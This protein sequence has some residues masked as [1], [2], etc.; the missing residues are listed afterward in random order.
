MILDW[1][2]WSSQVIKSLLVAEPQL[3][4]PQLML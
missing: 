2:T 1:R 4:F 3:M